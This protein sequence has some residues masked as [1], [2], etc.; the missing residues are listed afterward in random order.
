M[1]F[2]LSTRPRHCGALIVLILIF[3]SCPAAGGDTLSDGETVY[4]PIYSNVYYGPK[5]RA[6]HLSAILS[7]RNTDP[8]HT[9]TLLI[10]DYYDNNGKRIER[11]VK[12]PIEL[13]P[14]AS[15]DFHIK[16]YDERGGLGANFIVKW[17]A[18]KAVNPPIIEGLMLGM[19]SG[20]GISFI[21]PGKVIK[22]PSK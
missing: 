19:K 14:L 13:G 4:V 15:T 3:V 21:C 11:Y 17:R 20:Q 12:K 6:F 18:D 7:I 5:G 8:S 10:A 2:S 16:E 1:T 9:I 22:K